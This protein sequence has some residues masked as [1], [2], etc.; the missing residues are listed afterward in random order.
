MLINKSCSSYRLRWHLCLSTIWSKRYFS[1]RWTSS[2]LCQIFSFSVACSFI[3]QLSEYLYLENSQEIPN[4][5]HIIPKNNGLF[6]DCF[7]SPW[8]SLVPKLRRHNRSK[9][10][11]YWRE[12]WELRSIFVLC[13]RVVLYDWTF[14]I[15]YASDFFFFQV[16]SANH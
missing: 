12:E 2:M 8:K 7:A 9:V 4:G 10:L 6:V 1:C 11:E 5:L 16:Q 14:W 15:T 3:W 13:S